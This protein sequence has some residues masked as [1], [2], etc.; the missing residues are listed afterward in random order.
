VKYRKLDTNGDYSLGVWLSNSPETVGQAVKTRLL[1]WRGEW[2]MNKSE[3]TPYMQD[4]LGRNTNYDLQ[5][6]A[7][8]LGTRGVKEII[9][10]SS[11]VIN[12]ALSVTCTLSTIYGTIT[13]SL[14]Q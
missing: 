10:Y 13:L 8:I 4:I 3:G 7:R 9:D 2:F 14:P 5:I 11:N 6:K 1:L 12:R